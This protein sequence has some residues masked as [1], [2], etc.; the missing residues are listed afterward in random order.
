VTQIN[1]SVDPPTTDAQRGPSIW[2]YVSLAPL[3]PTADKVI[4]VVV[5]VL[6]RS[7]DLFVIWPSVRVLSVR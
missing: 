6:I 4:Y 5:V 2:V 1:G 3:R 7:V